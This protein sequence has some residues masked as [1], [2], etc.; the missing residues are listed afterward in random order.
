MRE[1]VY[2]KKRDAEE[3]FLAIRDISTGIRTL[4][5]NELTIG[6]VFYLYNFIMHKGKLGK[7]SQFVS[8][9]S[10]KHKDINIILV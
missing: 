8:Q 7:L 10:K 9:L 3:G 6:E 5:G 2:Q 4:S 1:T